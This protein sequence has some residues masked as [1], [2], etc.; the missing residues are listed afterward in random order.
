MTDLI[1]EIEKIIK[2]RTKRE[3]ILGFS[4][5]EGLVPKKY[6]SLVYGITVGIRLD[7][8]I[9]DKIKSGPT[10]EYLKHYHNINSTLNKIAFDIK[11][12]INSHRRKAEVIR[13]TLETDEE[14]DYPNY[15]ETLSVD[16][17]HKMAATRSG[18]GWIGK[19]ALFVSPRYGPRLR[20]VSVLTTQKF[21][22]GPP[23]KTSLCGECEICVKKCPA[24][25]ANGKLWTPG[26]E[27]NDFYDAHA[28]RNKA[29]ELTQTR[30]KKDD[31]VCGICV[32]MCPLGGEKR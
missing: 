11:D 32:A 28:C 17:S 12:L 22:T 5:L 10:S 23:V 4:Y 8:K 20:L 26:V 30:L 2:K 13:S 31:T 21:D 14:E 24:S 27:R 29:R 16:F 18:L 9:I 1:P 6:K 15:F 19:T 25:A 3:Y 7:D